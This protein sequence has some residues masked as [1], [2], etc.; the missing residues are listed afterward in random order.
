[1]IDKRLTYFLVGV[2]L[3]LLL[4]VISCEDREGIIG[5]NDTVSL[6]TIYVEKIIKVPQ[7]KEVFIDSTPEAQIIYKAD[8]KLLKQYIDLEDENQRLKKYAEAVTKSL[9]ERTYVSA[10]SIVKIIVKDSV[11]GTLDFQSVDFNVSEREVLF[12]EKIVTKTIE[13]RPDFSLSLGAGIRIPT[14]LSEASS[15]EVVIGMKSRKGFNYQLGV[16]TNKAFRFMLTKDI[17]I[18]Y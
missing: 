18:K 14:L 6:D 8:P 9:Y 17:F 2:F 15:I 13:K 1:M 3:T 11:T 7:I 12:K 16:D 5:N 10:D 4:N